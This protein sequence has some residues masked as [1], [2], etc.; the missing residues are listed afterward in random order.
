MMK[1]Q[2]LLRKKHMNVLDEKATFLYWE[3][4]YKNNRFSPIP[5]EQLR[6]WKEFIPWRMIVHN[7]PLSQNFIREMKD[8]FKYIDVQIIP[9]NE[10]RNLDADF[11]G[12][13]KDICDGRYISYKFTLTN[14]DIDKFSDILDWELLTR[15][16][17]KISEEIL[18][19]YKDKVNWANVFRYQK[20]INYKF[21]DK[22]KNKEP[23]LWRW[24]KYFSL[25][26]I[27][28]KYD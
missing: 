18:E 14:E 23:S 2:K 26:A 6:E 19:K 21:M 11:L 7:Q 22:Y 20:N 9:L 16:Q 10:K 28:S 15:Y 8:Y 13:V 24:R 1:L 25:G 3:N 12:E 27:S 5:E 4:R 17:P